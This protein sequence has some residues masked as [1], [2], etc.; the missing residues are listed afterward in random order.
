MDEAR[1]AQLL[2]PF[3]GELAPERLRQISTYIDILLRWNEKTNLTAVREP[4]QIV[5]RHFGES[6]FAARALLA[7]EAQ[8]ETIDVGSGAGF[9]GMPLKLWA[10]RIR[11]TLVE[12]HAKKATFLREVVRALALG[13]VNVLAARAETLNDQ[14]DLVT[15]RAVEKFDAILPT[16]AR[17]VRPGGRLGLLIGTPQ[18]GAAHQ[19]PEFAWA[20]PQHVPQSRT[21]VLLVGNHA[22]QASAS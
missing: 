19:L 10:P 17:L 13:N 21:R 20:E 5:V 4:E 6:L 9:P 11:L 12:A 1:I 15:L 3:A 14:A 2:Q 8:L 7:P 16:A 18:V 22:Q